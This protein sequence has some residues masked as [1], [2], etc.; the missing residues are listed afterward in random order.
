[1]VASSTGASSC[2]TAEPGD[3]GPAGAAACCAGLL[4]AAAAA[5][6][7]AGAS[8][9]ELSNSSLRFIMLFTRS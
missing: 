3:R 1:M 8:P 5:R 4:P 6:K 7:D 2:A 9:G